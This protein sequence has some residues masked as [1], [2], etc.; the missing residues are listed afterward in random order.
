MLTPTQ[1]TAFEQCLSTSPPD[2][3]H[4][5]TQQVLRMFYSLYN[6]GILMPLDLFARLLNMVNSENIPFA[7][8]LLNIM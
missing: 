3:S 4:G 2:Y 6:D 5:P 7:E 1:Q 8:C